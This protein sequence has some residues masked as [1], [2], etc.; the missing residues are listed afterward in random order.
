M[1]QKKKILFVQPNNNYS[2]SC[3]VLLNVIEANYIDSDYKVLTIGTEG[4][5]KQL[6]NKR[7]LILDYPKFFGKI[8][9]GPSYIFFCIKIFIVVLCYGI[10]YRHIY[11]NTI[12]PFP[13]VIGGKIL[14]CQITY[15]V[16]E[17]F[18]IP[19]AKQRFAEWVFKHIES[20]KIYVSNYLREAYN[21]Y[22]KTSIVEYNHLSKH[23][24]DSVNIRPIK[25]RKRNTIV[26]VSA[27]ASKQKGVDL[28]YKLAQICPHYTFYLV[29]EM[30][31]EDV[32]S[33]LKE[34][35]LPNLI[36][37][38]GGREVGKYY[39]HS[40]LVVNM[41]NPIL[42]K[43]TFGMTILEGMA[44]GLPAIVPNA[45]GP[46]ELIED[47]FNGYRVNV[48]DIAEVKG[49]IEDIFDERNY[50]Q[51]CN[52]ASVMFRRLSSR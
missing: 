16:H 28:Y 17:K 31:Q 49:K 3:R 43:E 47:G 23:F 30:Q 9:H 35:E 52:N 1:A 18:I 38:K 5:L 39:Q 33:F 24:I 2:G 25:E 34:P 12:M 21:D 8:L 48:V 22:S 7:L 42:F 41:S 32:Y 13:A 26:L 40:D 50:E 44:Y 11:I 4:F 45:G 51:F 20:K 37:K 6:P 46:V 29:T 19:N 27:L 15:H 10:K 14:G 36:V